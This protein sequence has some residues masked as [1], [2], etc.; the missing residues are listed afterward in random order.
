MGDVDRAIGLSAR[1]TRK[2]IAEAVSTIHGRLVSGASDSELCSEMGLAVEE[3]RA[4]KSA[5]FDTEA[6]A[7]RRRP[8]EHV[9]V[10][11]MIKQ[12]QNVAD[13][14][15]MITQFKKS[16]QYNAMVGA[17]RA[18]SEIYDKLIDRG[19]SFGLIH[20]QP[21][22]K[23]VVNGIVIAD[24]SNKELKGLIT[25]EMAGLQKMMSKYGDASIEELPSTFRPCLP[26]TP[27]SH[28][29]AAPPQSHMPPPKRRPRGGDRR[30]PPTHKRRVKMGP[31]AV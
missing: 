19:Q 11:Y 7:L 29:E 10:D 9:Y 15:E 28:P 22:R 16:K 24:L 2:Q 4:L 6:E 17:I 23:E 25:S 21:D 3:Y 1:W 30:P 31:I 12:S 13:L 18:R 14:T 8:V 5:M 26:P 27:T 20:K